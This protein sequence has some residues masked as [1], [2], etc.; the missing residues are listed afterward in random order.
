MEM[1]QFDAILCSQLG[2]NKTITCPP[3]QRLIHHIISAPPI[4]LISCCFCF[5]F[6][7]FFVGLLAIFW[8]LSS[9]RE[10]DLF[11]LSFKTSPT[12]NAR[13]VSRRNFCN[14]KTKVSRFLLYSH[15]ESGNI[16]STSS[17]VWWFLISRQHACMKA[18]L[19]ALWKPHPLFMCTNPL[20]RIQ[21]QIEL[22][23]ARLFKEWEK[24]S[25]GALAKWNF[26][27]TLI[28]AR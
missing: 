11:V 27:S 1:L 7:C 8:R 4:T 3:P 13:W 14:N 5:I 6:A 26:S 2:A 24:M 17:C 28:E 22:S 15:I 10:D 19:Q 16:C 25:H 23:W 12:I 18:L 20:R 9:A 21:R